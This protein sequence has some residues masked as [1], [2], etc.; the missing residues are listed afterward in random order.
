MRTSNPETATSVV[1]IWAREALIRLQAAS[2]HA[3]LANHL[4]EKLS[5]LEK[6]LE[7]TSI[8]MPVYEPCEGKNTEFIK[9]EI[10]TI[11]SKL[12]NEKLESMGIIPEMTFYISEEGQNPTSPVSYNRNFLVFGFSILGFFVGIVFL[13]TIKFHAVKKK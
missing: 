11:S 2:M 12:Q 1:N 6:C 3:L 8:V 4:A 9:G 13:H 5:S 10:S 7:S